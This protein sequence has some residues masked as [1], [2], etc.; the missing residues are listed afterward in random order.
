MWDITDSLSIGVVSADA[1]QLLEEHEGDQ[2]VRAD[3]LQAA[4][5]LADLTQG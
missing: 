2:R 4:V 5:D 3:H 1:A